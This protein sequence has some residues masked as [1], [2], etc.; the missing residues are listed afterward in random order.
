MGNAVIKIFDPV[1]GFHNY[2]VFLAKPCLTFILIFLALVQITLTGLVLYRAARKNQK[3]WFIFF[4]LV[5]TIIIEIIYLALTREKRK[6]K[7]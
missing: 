4:L 1:Y 6:K 2:S 3:A 5:H 7:K